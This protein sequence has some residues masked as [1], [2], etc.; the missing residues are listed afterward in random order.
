M[1]QFASE[2]MIDFL[3]DYTSQ[4]ELKDKEINCK[5][6][7]SFLH[8]HKMRAIKRDKHFDYVFYSLES[9]YSVNFSLD[10]NS[11][12][13]NDIEDTLESLYSQKG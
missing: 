10:N 13:C 6:V 4:S 3:R 5:A 2:Q 12:K 7:N 11:L 8:R 1:K 9:D